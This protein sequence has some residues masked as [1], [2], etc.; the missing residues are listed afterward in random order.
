MYHVATCSSQ[1]LKSY[2]QAKDFCHAHARHDVYMHMY[3][4]M[5]VPAGGF[6]CTRSMVNLLMSS[7]DKLGK[8]L[9]EPGPS[10]TN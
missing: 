10:A 9:A 6:E 7:R 1:I 2:T 4:Y 5:Y 3:V 8:S